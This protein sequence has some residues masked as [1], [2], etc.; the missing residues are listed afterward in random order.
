M[1]LNATT[2]QCD[3]LHATVHGW[4]QSLVVDWDWQSCGSSPLLAARCSICRRTAGCTC[5]IL[6]PRRQSQIHITGCQRAPARREQPATELHLALGL[7]HREQR[8]PTA[9]QGAVAA[10]EFAGGSR[11]AP[12]ERWPCTP[13][14]GFC[15]QPGPSARQHGAR[16]HPVP[17]E[18][19]ADMPVAPLTP[20]GTAGGSSGGAG[21]AVPCLHPLGAPAGQAPPA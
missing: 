11:D 5:P 1:L 14:W 9:T 7:C 13:M 17:P 4:Q 10:C 8:L 19:A 3:M 12:G 21:A 20:A 6:L 2:Q 16:K 15:S 18:H